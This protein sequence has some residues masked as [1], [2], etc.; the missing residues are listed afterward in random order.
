[1]KGFLPAIDIGRSVSRIGSKAQSPALKKMAVR[2]KLDYSQF[3]EVE[4]IT[5]FGAKV[6]EQT[7]KL[8]DRGRA[9]RAALKQKRFEHIGMPEQVLIFFLS[10]EGY[11]QL[12]PLT[13][14]EAFIE[15]FTLHIR[16]SAPDI[17]D[18]IE[19]TKEIDEAVIERLQA[20][21]EK[22]SKGWHR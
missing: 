3:L 19:V 15:A 5:K 12:Q 17:L 10:N 1:N 8:I 9:L 6:E 18:T 2:L 11:L 21:A 13:D 4:V 20:A 7:Q 22:F 14:V 16:E